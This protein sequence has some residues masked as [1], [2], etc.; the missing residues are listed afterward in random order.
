MKAIAAAMM[1]SAMIVLAFGCKKAKAPTVETTQTSNITTTTATIGGFVTSDG[2]SDVIDRGVCWGLNDN[3]DVSTNVSNAG[4]GMG[5][6][7]CTLTDLLPATTY[8]ARAYAC[9]SVGVSYGVQVSFTTLSEGGGD[10]PTD[11]DNP[12]EPGEPVIYTIQISANPMFAGTVMGGGTFQEGETCTVSATANMDYLFANW[13]ENG[14]VVSTLQTYSFT[15]T[16]DQSLVADFIYVGAPTG[17]INGKFTINANGDQVY[18][19][20]GN[21]QYIGSAS[22]P[23]WKFADN[24]WDCLGTTTGQNSANSN[25]DR[26]YF[27]WGT[28][29]YHDTGDMYNLY[30]QPWSTSTATVNEEYNTYGYGPST[31]MASASLWGSSANYDWGVF[32]PISNGS[33]QEGLWRALT[34]G[35]NGEWYYIFDVRAAS[36]VNGV[37]DARFAKAVVADMPGVILFPDNY[38]HPSGVAQPESINEIE[39]TG[40]NVNNYSSDDFAL[41]Q[42]AGAVFLPAAGYR[43]GTTV[44]CV[45]TEGSYWS[46]SCRNCNESYRVYFNDVSLYSDSWRVR[47]PGRSVR[48]VCPAVNY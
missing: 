3:P 26:D 43:I 33:N 24:Q 35:R 41:M 23:Y 40:W 38:T 32:N 12:D 16:G 8:Y 46:S 4:Q 27:G 39:E 45:G 36:T 1:L 7:S 47:Y 31:N 6:F 19:S 17:A 21:L 42:S 2:G 37:A 28:S 20:Q 22:K 18:F 34:G 11:P 29:G 14:N 5:G 25:V 30:Y 9:N 48:L 10:D 15:V 13:T 44:S